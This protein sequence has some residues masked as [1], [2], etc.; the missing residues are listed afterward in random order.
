MYAGIDCGTQ[1]S[2]VVIY[3]PEQAKCIGTGYCEHELISRADG[4]R[5]QH[6][7]WWINAII[8]A[9]REALDE[10][11]LNPKDIR[12][13]GVSGQQ[14]GLVVLDKNDKVI[15]PAKLWCDTSTA[16]ENEA[17]VEAIGGKTATIDS[18]GQTIATGYTVSKLLW[19]KQYEAQN[20]A[21]IKSILLPHDYINFW[22]TGEKTAEFGDASG[23]GFFDTRQRGWSDKVLSLVDE[24]IDLSETLPRLISAQ[25]PAGELCQSA[26]EALGLPPGILVS[27]GG[28]D[29]MMGGDRHR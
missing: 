2:K 5:E 1:G 20:Y 6:P 16:A 19:L 22:L 7:D 27:S 23:T 28:G 4:T 9:F 26:A 24:N 10:S 21:Q 15:R 3:D 25:E 18:I 14:H 8:D 13:I 11:G 29:N 17:L 12:G